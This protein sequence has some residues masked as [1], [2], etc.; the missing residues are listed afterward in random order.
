MRRDDGPDDPSFRSPPTSSFTSGAPMILALDAGD[1]SDVDIV[2]SVTEYETTLRI[3]PPAPPT[4]HRAGASPE[5]TES[6]MS[7]SIAISSHLLPS[8]S[9]PPR[10]GG[11]RG[12]NAGSA[13]HHGSTLTLSGLKIDAPVRY[14]LNFCAF[15]IDVPLSRPV[16]NAGVLRP[17][18]TLTS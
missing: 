15:T 8:A 13:A 10:A 17:P 5:S 16:T 3:T 14:L 2:L 11:Y 7:G 1:D 6:P 9:S 18:A 12:A 4:E